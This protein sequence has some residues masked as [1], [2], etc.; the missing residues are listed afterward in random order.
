M[1]SFNEELYT[2]L[3]VT[4]NVGVE[5]SCRKHSALMY[6]SPSM[7]TVH[8]PLSAALMMMSVRRRSWFRACRSRVEGCHVLA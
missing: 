2:C 7:I 8:D 1:Q 6:Q 3:D 4:S 5:S